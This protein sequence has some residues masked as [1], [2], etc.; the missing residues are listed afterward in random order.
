MTVPDKAD[1]RTLSEP[2]FARRPDAVSRAPHT[3]R[4]SQWK[5]SRKSSAVTLSGSSRGSRRIQPPGR[6][7]CGCWLRCGWPSLARTRAF[8]DVERGMPCAWSDH[9]RGEAVLARCRSDLCLLCHDAVTTPI[10]VAS[11]GAYLQ[12]VAEY[13]HNCCWSPSRAST[14]PVKLARETT[15]SGRGLRPACTRQCG[16]FSGVRGGHSVLG[17]PSRHRGVATG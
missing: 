11:A 13:R 12:M 1:C 6:E 2:H 15:C 16:V 14:R 3:G 17:Q 4:C 10:P 9:S 8:A 5:L 7:E